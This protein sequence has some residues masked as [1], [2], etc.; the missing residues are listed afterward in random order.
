MSVRLSSNYSNYVLCDIKPIIYITHMAL[1][2]EICP[3][4]A[5]VIRDGNCRYCCHT[6]ETHRKYFTYHIYARRIQKCF[7][8]YK[9]KNFLMKNKTTNSLFNPKGQLYMQLYYQYKKK[10]YRIWDK[11]SLELFIKKMYL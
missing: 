7:L 1:S 5:P 6:P 9:F 11:F 10:Y 2:K 8:E 4:Y 3:F